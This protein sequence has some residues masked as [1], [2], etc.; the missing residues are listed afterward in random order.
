MTKVKA[1][2]PLKDPRL[3]TYLTFSRKIDVYQLYIFHMGFLLRS[4]VCY[5]RIDK[6]PIHAGST[7]IMA[8]ESDD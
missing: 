8:C 7:C 3:F 1:A 5:N 2:D 4:A 6:L